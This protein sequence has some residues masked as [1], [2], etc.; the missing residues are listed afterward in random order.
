MQAGR[1]DFLFPNTKKNMDSK[2]NDYNPG[3]NTD[4]VLKKGWGERMWTG[5]EQFSGKKG[6][7]IF[8][9]NMVC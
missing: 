6:A 8:R 9:G 5:Q 2:Y 3:E 7:A 4:I 1:R